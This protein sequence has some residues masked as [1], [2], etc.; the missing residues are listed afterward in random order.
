M[1]WLTTSIRLPAEA[2]AKEAS[3]LGS[4]SLSIVAD[5]A[6]AT[7]INR[8]VETT[9]KERGRVDILVN[10]AMKI[11]PGKL[12]ALPEA[13]WD[14]T[15]NIGLKGAFLMSQSNC[16]VGSGGFGLPGDV[17]AQHGVE[18]SEKTTAICAPPAAFAR[19]GDEPANLRQRRLVR[20]VDTA[21]DQ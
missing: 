5:V 15:M 1:W 12:E 16:D 14:T 2:T 11:V 19:D 8:M 6:K 21:S 13:A 17:V 9:V 20:P 7:D 18:G 10:N 4:K 3:D